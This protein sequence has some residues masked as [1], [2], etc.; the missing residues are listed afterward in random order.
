MSAFAAANNTLFSDPNGSVAAIYTPPSGAAVALRVIYHVDEIDSSGPLETPM[1]APSYFAEIRREDVA[2][3]KEG[4]ELLV[5]G[6]RYRVA[7]KKLMPHGL[8]WFC[9]LERR[10]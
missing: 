5:E 4:A 2:E 7:G 1:Y 8:S 6:V 3:P 10:G 9:D